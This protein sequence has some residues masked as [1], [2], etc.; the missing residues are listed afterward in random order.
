MKHSLDSSGRIVFE[1]ENGDYFL[2]VNSNNHWIISTV[3]GQLGGYIYYEGNPFCVND[4]QEGKW[5]V[6][7][8]QTWTKDTTMS[9]ACDNG[10]IRG[11]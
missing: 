11:R 7:E 2:Y 3:P 6:V 5:H 4:A 1:Q 8:N 9:V 10:R